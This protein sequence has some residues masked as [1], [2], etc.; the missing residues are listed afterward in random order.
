[1][2]LPASR[3]TTVCAFRRPSTSSHPRCNIRCNDKG[4]DM[5]FT[6]REFLKSCGRGMSAATMMTALSYAARENAYAAQEDYKALVCLFLEGG[7]DCW[8][9]VIPTDQSEYNTYATNRGALALS[10]GSL[11]PISVP[12]E[13]NFGMH[14]SLP[15]IRSL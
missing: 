9:T 14:P 6:R 12:G 4:G 11:L 13:G 15:G 3:T 10:Q 2:R 5:S 8:N 7:N 1:M